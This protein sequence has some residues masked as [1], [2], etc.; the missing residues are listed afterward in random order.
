VIFIVDTERDEVW[1]AKEDYVILPSTIDRHVTAEESDEVIVAAISCPK[2][3]E[4]I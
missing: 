4:G 1:K 3:E 2:H